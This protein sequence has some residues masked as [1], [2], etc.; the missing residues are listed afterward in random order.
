ML[1]TGNK[2][3][4]ILSL[5]FKIVLT[6]L[7]SSSYEKNLCFQDITYIIGYEKTKSNQA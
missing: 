2:I 6:S 5:H 7:S 4:V 1:N 3:G